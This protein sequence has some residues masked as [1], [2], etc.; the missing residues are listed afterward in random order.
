[1]LTFP[2]NQF[3]SQQNSRGEKEVLASL[4]YVRPGH[5]FVPLSTMFDIVDVN[6]ANEH[7]LFTWLKQE[8]PAP[9]DRPEILMEDPRFIMWRPVRRS[10]ISW[11]FEK[12][13][14]DARGRPRRRYSNRYEP[15][16]ISKDIEKL[17]EHKKRQDRKEDDQGSKEES[18]LEKDGGS[19]QEGS[20]DA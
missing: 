8:L 18:Q 12:F 3:G 15:R 7:P 13:L 1:V 9:E 14:I 11:N 16:H 5:G 6:G 2:C 10:D 17:I 20:Q 4:A 19:G